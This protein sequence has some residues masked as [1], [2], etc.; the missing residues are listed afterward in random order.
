MPGLSVDALSELLAL[1]PFLDMIGAREL[2]RLSCACRALRALLGAGGAQWAHVAAR[3][4]IAP[5]ADGPR[6]EHTAAALR[7]ELWWDDATNVGAHITSRDAKRALLA[8]GAQ[9]PGYRVAA[10]ASAPWLCAREHARARTALEWEVCVHQLDAP[11]PVI[12]WVGL[13]FC[14]ALEPAERERGGGAL[15]PSTV[16]QLLAPFAPAP[17]AGIAE[18][19]GVSAW[20]IIALGSNGYVW[21]A[22]IGAR[23]FG[24]SWVRS[25]REPSLAGTDVGS[26]IA[27]GPGIVRMRL[28]PARGVLSVAVADVAKAKL[29]CAWGPMRV[30]ARRV[31]PRGAPPPERVYVI[32]Q[33]T[34]IVAAAPVVTPSAA[35]AR[36]LARA[37]RT[38]LDTEDARCAAP[39]EQA[40]HGEP[41]V[42]AHTAEAH[43][44]LRRAGVTAFAEVELGA[45]AVVPAS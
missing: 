14:G 8:L 19:F 11:K 24:P 15:R 16:T 6:G 9:P 1:E 36:A 23:A 12:L 37:A 35:H 39:A 33:L 31:F 21:G 38:A 4:Q 40:A 44:V 25:A 17:G 29:P 2:C 42:P 7:H 43:R 5:R 20:P 30:V 34:D 28:D 3:L 32:A 26:R 18:R 22:G 10:V 27:R 13:T 45:F 41:R